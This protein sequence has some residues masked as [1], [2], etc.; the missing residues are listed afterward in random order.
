MVK[1]V[2]CA[3]CTIPLN[4][5]KPITENFAKTLLETL[6]Q[7]A[8]VVWS[9]PLE[10]IKLLEFCPPSPRLPETNPVNSRMLSKALSSANIDH[11]SVSM[12]QKLKQLP[13]SVLKKLCKEAGIVNIEETKAKLAKMLFQVVEA[14]E[15]ECP[16][17]LSNKEIL[18]LL[19]EGKRRSTKKTLQERF[20]GLPIKTLRKIAKAKHVPIPLC[21]RDAKKEKEEL[22]GAIWQEKETYGHRVKVYKIRRALQD[23]RPLC[24]VRGIRAYSKLRDTREATILQLRFRLKPFTY[25][26][27]E[28]FCLG[29]TENRLDFCIVPTLTKAEVTK[30][31]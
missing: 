24:C 14:A 29:I 21:P 23:T 6:P 27:T 18:S 17:D 15:K 4:T 22:V 1:T 10:F 30:Y 2:P 8:R 3:S 9:V 31:W 7:D 11:T 28:V 26:V 16:P 19:K 25:T 20:A 13:L 5:R 12:P